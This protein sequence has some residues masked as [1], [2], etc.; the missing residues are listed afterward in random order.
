MNK[1]T[2]LIIFAHPAFQRS[3]VNRA[4]LDAAN[5]VDSVLVHDLY[6]QYPD[7]DIDVKKE[8]Q[9]LDQ[10][11]IIILQ[12]PMYWFS[13]PSLLKEWQDLSLLHG[14]AYGKGATALKDKLLL[15]VISTG[16][17]ESFYN[18]DHENNFSIKELISPYAQL[19]KV[20]GMIY[21]PPFVVHSTHS[22]NTDGINAH[23]EDYRNI[24]IALTENRLD[25]EAAK[26]MCRLNFDISRIIK[27]G[28]VKQ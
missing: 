17:D 15:S 16:A 10:C 4:L 23:A 8:Q 26:S 20:C 12:H 11:D 1:K 22:L 6:E 19:A 3:R 18:K 27:T 14:W 25:I 13:A 5:G 24:L 2:A 7:F 21:L 9:L 28:Q